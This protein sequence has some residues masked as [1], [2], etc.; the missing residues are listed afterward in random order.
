MPCYR[1]VYRSLIVAEIS[2]DYRRI[3]SPE[4]VRRK[5][6]CKE[7]MRLIGLCNEQKSARI[8]IY[9]MND[10]GTQHTADARQ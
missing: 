4:L 1:R 9:T 8:L 7:I 2:D 10:T 3:Y 5:L 6:L